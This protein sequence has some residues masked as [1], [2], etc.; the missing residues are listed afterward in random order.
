MTAAQ[1]SITTKFLFSGDVAEMFTAP[2]SVGGFISMMFEAGH[3]NVHPDG[4]AEHFET[5][6]GRHHH[7]PR[8]LLERLTITSQISLDDFLAS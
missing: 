6:N 7:A 5:Y 2:P 4:R 1:L 8:Q 3:V